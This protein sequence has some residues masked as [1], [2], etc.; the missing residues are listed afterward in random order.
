M[1]VRLEQLIGVEETVAHSASEI[2]RLDAGVDSCVH[3]S[4]AS[5]GL[6]VARAAE[7]P[8]EANGAVGVVP[9]RVRPEIGA[10]EGARVPELRLRPPERDALDG[11]N[12]ATVV[13][14]YG[15]QRP[16][17]G[18]RTYIRAPRCASC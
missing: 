7:A 18:N 17:H 10:V 6:W 4:V 11:A 12:L 2:D 8:V 16:A 15:V 13:V 3:G 5:A 1:T 9:V 14:V